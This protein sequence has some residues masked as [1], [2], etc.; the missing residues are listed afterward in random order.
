MSSITVGRRTLL[1]GMAGVALCAGWGSWRE[2]IATPMTPPPL[3]GLNLAGAEFGEVYPGTPGR[4][5]VYPERG[6]IDRVANLGFTT[7]RLPFRWERLQPE[8]RGPFEESEWESLEAVI[9]ACEVNELSL[10]L[11]VHNYAGRRVSQDGFKEMHRIGSDLVPSAAFSWFW[12][13]LAE[14]IKGREYVIL[15]L[16]NE[17]IELAPHD[18]LATTNAAISAIRKAD[19]GQLLLVPGVDWT[20]AHSWYK[21]GNTALEGVRDPSDNFAIEVHQY[22]DS[23]N[24]GRSPDPVSTSIGSQRIE[25][26]QEWARS[27]GVRAFLGEFGCGPSPRGVAAMDEILCEMSRSPEVWI[28]W[29]AWAA[30]A[31]WP[32]DYPLLLEPGPDGAEQPQM[33]VLQRYA[34]HAAAAAPTSAL[35][36]APDLLVDFAKGD[37]IGVDS[38]SDALLLTRASP[39]P[40][41]ARSGEVRVFEADTPRITDLGLRLEAAGETILEHDDLFGAAIGVGGVMSTVPAPT[42]AEDAVALGLGG[43]QLRLWPVR[44]LEEAGWASFG[45]FAWADP[46]QHLELEVLVGGERAVFDFGAGEA[47]GV[48]GGMSAAISGSGEWRWLSLTWRSARSPELFLHVSRNRELDLRAEGVARVSLWRP[49]LEAGGAA[50]LFEG[51]ERSADIARLQ[52][53]ITE[54]LNDDDVTIMIETRGLSMASTPLPILSL[55]RVLALGRSENGA[56][57]SDWGGGVATEARP[58]A[59]WTHRQRSALTWSRSQG[60]GAIAVTN[61]APAELT[62]P[63]EIGEILLGRNGIEALNGQVTRVA[64]YR[65]S[66]STEELSDLVA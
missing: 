59:S 7:I 1:K 50:T 54:A 51:L 45:I 38:V 66:M 58:L 20:G 33:A 37:L 23:D 39:A 17:P 28:G 3:T 18:W 65:R 35:A 30:G 19:A 34:I 13:A 43:Q 47:H 15:G 36:G 56:L 24:S 14:R 26:F 9:Q 42:G 31:W 64:V 25:A 2:A 21:A 12:E 41:F 11:N 63:G 60:R 32:S 62:W 27:R 4:D 40:A 5:Y 48:S 52:G 16:M 29:T 61:A 22:L 55:N 8:L 10:I 44:S 6:A 57:T 46:R 49:T 53:P